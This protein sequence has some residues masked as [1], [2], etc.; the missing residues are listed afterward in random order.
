MTDPYHAMNNTVPLEL[1]P[2][3]AD[4]WPVEQI[5]R[6]TERQHLIDLTEEEFSA[7]GA[8]VIRLRAQ[9]AAQEAT[10]QRWQPVLDELVDA[11]DSEDTEDD[12]VAMARRLIECTKLC[13]WDEEYD[14]RLTRLVVGIIAEAG[15]SVS[16][17]R[18]R[19]HPDRVNINGKL[20]SV[21]D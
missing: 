6:P 4:D 8:A 3:D 9:K 21:E 12:S 5:P 11:L 1:S 19:G 15:L 17:E 13:G 10:R 7:A 16:I 2:P 18:R 14:D 20:I